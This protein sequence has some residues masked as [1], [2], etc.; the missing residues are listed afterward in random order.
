MKAGTQQTEGRVRGKNALVKRVLAD[1]QQNVSARRM[2]NAVA[3]D[4]PGTCAFTRSP[5]DSMPIV[6]RLAPKLPRR[7][8]VKTIE[9]LIRMA[10]GIAALEEHPFYVYKPP[11]LPLHISVGQSNRLSRRLRR[12]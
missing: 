7:C 6:K 3:G 9:R 8:K 1:R 4:D 2:P 10:G 5:C 11:F 12:E